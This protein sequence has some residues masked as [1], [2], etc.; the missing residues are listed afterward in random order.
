MV[1]AACLR[2]LDDPHD[3]KDARQAAF[4]LLSNKVRELAAKNTDVVGRL[5]QTAVFMARSG[6]RNKVIRW[7]R[8]LEAA[9]MCEAKPAEETVRKAEAWAHIRTE[10]DA[11]LSALPAS[12]RE[13]SLMRYFN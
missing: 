11:A 2:I 1:R 7:R 4:L 5:H 10:L 8:E 6:L 13:A 12:Q 9:T 3:A